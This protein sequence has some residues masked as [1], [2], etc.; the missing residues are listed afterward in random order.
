[1]TLFDIF[2]II[3]IAIIIIILQID[4]QNM[5]NNMEI[6]IFKTMC[7]ICK[8]M[9]NMQMY[10]KYELTRK[11][12]YAKYALLTLQMPV[13]QADSGFPTRRFHPARGRSRWPGQPV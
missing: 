12:P 6:G 2:C 5:Q 8:H 11:I 7:R 3:C 4:M 1:M 10:A 9:Q 13:A